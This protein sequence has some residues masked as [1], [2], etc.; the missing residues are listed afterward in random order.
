MKSKFSQKENAKIFF[1]I[2]ELIIRKIIINFN[3]LQTKNN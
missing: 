2:K 1:A 3:T